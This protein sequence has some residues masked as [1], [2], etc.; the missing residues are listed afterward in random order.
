MIVVNILIAILG[1]TGTLTAFGGETWKKGEEPLIRRITKRGYLSLFCLSMTFILGVFKEV[2]TNEQKNL[3]VTENQELNKIIK[4]LQDSLSSNVKSI[5]T[6]AREVNIKVDELK[7]ANCEGIEIAFK[8]AVNIPRDYDDCVANIDGRDKITISGRITDPMEIYWGDNFEYTF[9][10]ENFSGEVSQLGTIKL[11]V[12]NRQYDLHPGN[13]N[14]F[15][16]GSVRIYGANPN[17]MTA[18]IIN[19]SNIA[20]VKI[21]IFVRSTDASRGQQ[22]FKKAVLNGQCS[23]YAKKVYKVINQNTVRLRAQ[24]N[25]NSRVRSTLLKGAFVRTLQVVEDW[26]EVLTP[27]NRQGWIKTDFLSIIKE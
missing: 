8:L 20:G 4:G 7:A 10:L 22:D 26:T 6:S 11:M 13:G 23:E 21:K 15:F 17:P 9:I 16:H 12:D 1:L 5:S 27:E 3:A 2:K 24:S 18:Y 19:P 25:E 14:Y